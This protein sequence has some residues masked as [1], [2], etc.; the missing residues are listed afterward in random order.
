LYYRISYL[1]SGCC[2]GHGAFGHFLL[3]NPL[4]CDAGAFVIYVTGEFRMK[5]LG[6][7]FLEHGINEIPRGFLRKLNSR[8]L[9]GI[10]GG[11]RTL[12]MSHM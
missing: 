8:K 9:Q 7:D 2:G 10:S 11:R 5:L 12:N 3:T 4:P 1:F 6:Q